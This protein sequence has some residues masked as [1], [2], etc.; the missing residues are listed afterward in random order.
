MYMA[1]WI[2][3]LDDFL[4]LSDRDILT[5]AGKVSHEQAVEKAEIELEK[6]RQAQATLPQPVD[7]HFDQTL[8]ALK[9]L[10]QQKPVNPKAD[11]PKNRNP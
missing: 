6:Y 2:A 4:R 9:R 11:K 8:D 3:K 10:E 5:H 7:G 1:D